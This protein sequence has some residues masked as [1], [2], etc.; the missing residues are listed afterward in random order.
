MVSLVE[1][2]FNKTKRQY[3]SSPHT[4]THTNSNSQ[5]DKIQPNTQQIQVC[6]KNELLSKYGCCPITIATKSSRNQTT[7]VIL[8]SNLIW[9][10]PKKKKKTFYEI[11]NKTMGFRWF[12]D[13]QGNVIMKYLSKKNWREVENRMVVTTGDDSE[14][15]DR[16]CREL[17]LAVRG[18]ELG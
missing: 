13:L 16:Q 2:L 7:F 18:S 11:L 6:N 15:L 12:L 17:G 5:K 14:T 8:D 1:P 9:A 4:H 10:H 3:Q